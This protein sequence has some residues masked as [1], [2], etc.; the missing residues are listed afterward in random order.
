[1]TQED[2]QLLLI[3]LCARLP[4]GVQCS[5]TWSHEVPNGTTGCVQELSTFLIDEIEIMD[6]PEYD[7][8]ICD[9]KPYLRPMSSMTE[10]EKEYIKNRWCYNDW[11]IDGPSSLWREKIDVE[12]ADGIIDYFNA[13]HFDYRG[14]IEKG[15]ALEAPEGMYEG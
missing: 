10:E 14:L 4:Y 13:H 12:D 3:D 2:K 8:Q 5:C 1:M 15:L 9:V 7:C 6:N 11:D